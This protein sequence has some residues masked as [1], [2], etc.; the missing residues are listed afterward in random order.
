[1]LFGLSSQT[2]ITDKWQATARFGS[3]DGRGH[4]ENPSLS[5]TPFDSGFGI[6]GLGNVMTITGANGYSVTGRGTLD[7]GP[8]KSD[9]RSTRQG[10][11]G[12]TT[13]QVLPDLSLAG[14]VN[15]ER[16]QGFPSADIDGRSDDDAQQPRGVGRGQRHAR[17]SRQ[18]HG[19][20]R[21]R[22]QRSVRERATRRGC[23]SRRT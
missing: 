9:S 18:H 17:P 5:G 11:Y 16:E 14:G 13:Y 10:F 20:P 8:S 23:R 15:V 21:L 7:F 4:F 3:W 6:I 22:A 1:M 2:Q 19:R 12:Q